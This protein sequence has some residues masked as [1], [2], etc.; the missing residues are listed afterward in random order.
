[1]KSKKLRK[2][3]ASVAMLAMTAG[4]FGGG[5]SAL[6]VTIPEFEKG[7]AVNLDSRVTTISGQ[8]VQ[9]TTGATKTEETIMTVDKIETEVLT[10]DTIVNVNI[11]GT[12]TSRTYKATDSEGGVARV[13][14]RLGGK[15]ESYLR[16]YVTDAVSEYRDN[17]NTVNA[18]RHNNGTSIKPE[19]QVALGERLYAAL[20]GKNSS[21]N[22]LNESVRFIVTY[23]LSDGRT[24]TTSVGL[25]DI[26]LDMPVTDPASISSASDLRSLVDENGLVY[27]TLR[28]L[29]S[30]VT[31]T[32]V[33]LDSRSDLHAVTNAA[34]SEYSVQKTLNYTA[35]RVSIPASTW[36]L[37]DSLYPSVIVNGK[38]EKQFLDAGTSN[39]IE[40][41][42][43]F[44]VDVAGTTVTLVDILKDTDKVV[45][46]VTFTDRRG[47]TYNG[48]VGDF[49]EGKYRETQNGTAYNI[50]YGTRYR[51][52]KIAGLNTR[53]NYEFEYMDI[54]YK[55]GDGER[56]QRVRFDNKVATGEVTGNKYLSVTTSD[57]A[58]SQ[59]YAYRSLINGASS[60]YQVNVGRNSLEYL[61]KVDDT[62]NLDRLEV[63]GLR[64]GETYTV[65]NVKSED[66]KKDKSNW[67]AVKI[68]GLEEN[69]DYSFLSLETVYNENG[70]ERYGTPISL[71]RSSDN[72]YDNVLF[73][74]DNITSSNNRYNM[75][76]TTN[77]GNVSELWIDSQLKHE[78]VP[79][80]VKFYGR[81]KDADDILDKVNVYINNGGSYER[82]DDSNVK[83]EKTYRIVKGI[84]IDSN[85]TLDSTNKTITYPYVS[86][87]NNTI[88]I[89][90]NSVESASEMVEITITGISSDRSRDFRFDFTTKQDGNRVS[91]IRTGDIG[92]FGSIPADNTK[93]QQTVTRY[94]SGR[95]GTTKVQVNTSNVQVSGV[96]TTTANVTAGITNPDKEAINVEVAG[97]TGVTAK[98]NTEKNII[99]LSGLRA[100]TEYKDLKLTLKY[101]DKS[102]TITVPAFTT[103]T[104]TQVEVGVAGYVARVYRTFF[105]READQAGLLYWTERLAGGEETLSG[106]LRQL[107]FTPELI[108]KNLTNTQ[109]VERMYA[110]V[111][112]TGE[113]EGVA[114]W[115]SEIEKGIK[116]GNTQSQARAAVVERMLDTDEVKG[117][118]TKLGIK[119]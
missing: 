106:F 90:E 83:L 108:E 48:E 26:T 51:D 94:A 23:D 101:G 30:D 68:T 78:S 59:I 5:A 40:K 24:R 88:S 55:S 8:G 82:I 98:Y 92:A 81:V 71:G 118:A 22:W 100:G 75:F 64:G 60:L 107:S 56:T 50:N 61:V 69:R 80:G 41:D 37:T 15:L 33:E 72:R 105:N 36:V 47:N 109:F 66:G 87:G 11:N 2:L 73:P 70:R 19:K 4:V 115:V 32:N 43:H 77:N 28:G 62:T 86:S 113:A 111:D 63:R 67:F 45:T 110:I 85:G 104:T 46:G 102:T 57:Y 95:A 114:F 13:G 10:T 96:T 116:E 29:P 84:D 97:A 20:W 49:A 12:N 65:E 54:T 53:T 3:I 119:F 103:T 25:S 58:T 52:I 112:R 39:V 9:L 6:A 21:G 76:A 31:I 1:M 74:G 27:L 35:G 7:W 117:I 79:G 44:F 89:S 38:S 99:E 91:S 34:G 93:T 14:V 16:S 42:E 17:V 18:N